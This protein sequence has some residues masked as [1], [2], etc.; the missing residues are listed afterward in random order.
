MHKKRGIQ[1]L[2][3]VWGFQIAEVYMGMQILQKTKICIP[4]FSPF[5]KLNQ[6][7]VTTANTKL[8]QKQD[9][10]CFQSNADKIA[11]YCN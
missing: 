11:E 7:N 8:N 9:W 6:K 4:T 10:K 5:F 1:C 2:G 3:D